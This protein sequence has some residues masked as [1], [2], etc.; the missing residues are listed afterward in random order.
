MRWYVV[1][2]LVSSIFVI[3]CEAVEDIGTIKHLSVFH[4]IDLI[5]STSS[6]F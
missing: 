3:S 1:A 6:I 2:I 4:S 5:R